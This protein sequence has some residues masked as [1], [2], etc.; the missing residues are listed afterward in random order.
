MCKGKKCSIVL[1]N[2]CPVACETINKMPKK[3]VNLHT[4][5]QRANRL[6]AHINHKFP[7]ETPV[8]L[9]AI[10]HVELFEA[11]LLYTKT[12]YHVYVISCDGDILWP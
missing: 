8:P 11:F 3:A 12:M 5:K 1:F 7:F 4:R 2:L 9:Q 6:S 10:S